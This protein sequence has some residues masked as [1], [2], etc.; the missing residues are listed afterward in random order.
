MLA[1]AK[2]VV[3]AWLRSGNAGTARG[4]NAFLAEVL[5]CLPDGFPVRAVRADAGFFEKEFLDELE[6]RSLAYAIAVR[7]NR[8]VQRAVVGIQQWRP[9]GVG[10]EVGEIGYQTYKWTHPRRLVVVREEIRTRPEARGRRLFD[11]P[12]YTFHGVITSL[13]DAPED[14]WRFY[15]GRADSENRLK[16]L[17][18]DYG[19]DGFCLQ[20]FFGTEAVFRLTCVLFNL[21]AQFKQQVLHDEAPQLATVRHTTFVI[22]AILG[23]KGRKPILR[24]GLRGRWRER[25]AVLLARIATLPTVANITQTEELHHFQTPRPWQPR[26]PKRSPTRFHGPLFAFN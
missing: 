20:S 12:D 3:H 22:G 24:L 4:V 7:M 25:F 13:T 18:Y 5:A 17:K 21:M 8:L 2:V 23:T 11:I 1:G 26:R 6:T 10:L 16:E 19:A 15:N 14:V 9:F